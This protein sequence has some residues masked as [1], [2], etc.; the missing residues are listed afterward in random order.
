MVQYARVACLAAL[1]F[2][3]A[4]GQ[5][6]R[7]QDEASKRSRATQALTAE[8]SGSTAEASPTSTY[9]L[10]SLGSVDWAHW[11]AQGFVHKAGANQISDLTQ[12][13]GT[14]D[15]NTQDSRRAA[16]TDGT[17]TASA[18]DDHSYF[19]CNG[20]TGQGFSFTAPASP[21]TRTL[22]VY[23][24]GA[25]YDDTKVKLVAHLEDGSAPDFVETK[26]NTDAVNMYLTTIRYTA[27]S[28]TR[29]KVT[30]T[31]DDDQ[32]GLS[33]DIKAAWLS[34]AAG[35][36]DTTVTFE[37]LSGG[38]SLSSYGGISWGTASAGWKIWD[39]GEAYT[40]NAY[41]D[42]TD[43][44]EVVA[45]F[46]LPA[47]QVL[48][49][50]KV[51]GSGAAA[52]TLKVSS[53]GNPERVWTDIDATIQVKDLGWTTASTTVTVKVTCAS[54]YGAADLG[55]DD[56]V[57]GPVNADTTVTFEDLSDGASLASYGGISWGTESAGWKIWDGGPAYSR[58][59]YV[60]SNATSEVVT[61]FTLPAGQ[62]LKSFKVSG[63]GAAATLKVSSPGNPERVWTD[64]DTT[65][66]VKNLG[67]TSA[68][69]TVTVKVT[70][71]SEYGAADLGFDDLVYG[72][73]LGSASLAGS[74]VDAST[75]T[76]YTLSSLGS[77]DWAHWGAQGFVHKVGADQISDLTMLG[78]SCNT[79]T[80][81]SR[82][83]AWSA[84]SPVAS[85]ADDRSYFWC[86]GV[87]GQGF[88]FTAP[89]SPTQRTLTVYWGGAPY[90]TKVKLVAH[91]EDGSAPDFVQTKT[92]T[93]SVNMYLTTITYAAASDTRLK[94]TLTKDDAISGLSVDIK[95]AWLNAVASPPA[96]A[97]T[98]TF[99]DLSDGAALASY[100]GISWGG[101][102]PAW[103]IWDGGSVL[104]LNAYVDS[105]STSE[106]VATF[107]LPA[108]HVLKSLKI[109]GSGAPATVKFSS[110]GNP[111]RVYTDI[112]T[113]YQLKNLDWTTASSV[114]TVKITCAS[115]WGAADIAFDDISYGPPAPPF[116]P[117]L[118]PD[119]FEW[120]P[121]SL[122]ETR[123]LRDSFRWQDTTALSEVS[124][125]T[126]T[127]GGQQIALPP[128]HYALIYVRNRDELR[129]L[130]ELGIHYE[131]T[132]LFE[133]EWPATEQALRLPFEGD[134][135]DAGGIF[136]YS[137][138]PAQTYNALR[139]LTLAGTETYRAL[140]LR[141]V[142][143]DARAESGTVSWDFL[144]EN[145]RSYAP[146]ATDLTDEGEVVPPREVESATT[147]KKLFNGRWIRRAIEGIVISQKW[148]V[149][150]I[151][152]AI[153]AAVELFAPDLEL[154]IKTSLRDRTRAPLVRAWDD[155][156]GGYG[157]RLA[158]KGVRVFVT[159]GKFAGRLAMYDRDKLDSDGEATLQVARRKLRT[160]FDAE[161]GAAK[162]RFGITLVER[163]CTA[164]KTFNSA[165][166][167]WEI[168]VG[169]KEFYELAQI[170]DARD[171]AA[172]VM[173]FKP[174][175]A[176]VQSGGIGQLL[177]LNGHSFAPCF[178]APRSLPAQFDTYAGAL[179]L[180]GLGGIVGALFQSDIV[181]RA[182]DRSSRNTIVHEYG[183]FVMCTLLDD[184]SHAA[185]DRAWS[186]VI[187][188]VNLDSDASTPVK[189][190]NE[191]FA[192]WFVSQVTSSV[193]YFAPPGSESETLS[194]C[195][196]PPHVVPG[197]R[198]DSDNDC[199]VD[200]VCDPNDPADAVLCKGRCSEY[201]V[202]D[203]EG[204]PVLLCGS[205]PPHVSAGTVCATDNDCA[206]DRVCDP[207]D[208]VLCAGQCTV[209]DG[210]QRFI[211]K[212]VTGDGQGLEANLGGPFCPVEDGIIP[213]GS[214][215]LDQAPRK[216]GCYNEYK[217]W[218]AKKKVVG[219]VATLLHDVIDDG[220]S[221][222]ANT[223]CGQ[224]RRSDA[225]VW[226]ITDPKNTLFNS[227]SVMPPLQ[228]VGD[229]AIDRAGPSDITAVI[230]H[231][232]SL[233]AGATLD[234]ANLLPA[235]HHQLRALGHNDD[236]ICHLFALHGFAPAGCRSIVGDK[237]LVVKFRADPSEGG[238]LAGQSFGERSCALP[239]TSSCM[240]MPAGGL[241]M[242]ATPNQGFTFS[243][244]DGCGSSSTNAQFSLTNVLANA[245][246][247]AHFNRVVPP[248]NVT[249]GVASGSGSI[250]TRDAPS[251]SCGATSCTLPVGGSVT[252]IAVPQAGFD[253][254][255]W[256]G[257]STQSAGVLTLSSISSNQ[258]CRAS[259]TPIPTFTLTVNANPSNG[260]TVNPQT[261]T[262]TRSG[263]VNPR[264]T[265][266]AGFRFDHWSGACSGTSS[267]VW[268]TV[269]SN[270][271]CTAN[272]VRQF[273]VSASASP[274]NGGS[275]TVDNGGSSKTVDNGATVTLR[276]SPSTGFRFDRYVGSAQCTGTNPTLTINS[277]TSNVACTANFVQ[278][279]FTV[280]ATANPGGTATP[281]SPVTVNTG[282]SFTLRATPNAGQLFVGWTGDPSSRCTGTSAALPLSNITSNISCVANFGAIPR[283]T[284]S[285]SPNNANMGSI[286]ASGAPAGSCGAS[287]CTFNSGSSVTLTA[288]PKPGHV[289]VAWSA[290][291]TPSTKLNPVLSLSAVTAN[292]TCSALFVPTYGV[293]YTADDSAIAIASV[294]GRGPCS[295]GVCTVPATGSVTMVATIDEELCYINQWICVAP[296][297]GQVVK[298]ATASISLTQVQTPWVCRAVVRCDRPM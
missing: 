50:F 174:P 221:C 65:I 73:V 115:Q 274:S 29:L 99:Q 184:A 52:A 172:N 70:C 17:P 105:S 293:T 231:I 215:E 97:T 31:K 112:N 181:M 239:A 173:G 237:L 202:V 182:D 193:N 26:T 203:S 131:L 284:V 287:S 79:N 248:V 111:E 285:F 275:V 84:G 232:A 170:I 59:A 68:S 159:G 227:G 41:V 51:S 216:T 247:V 39:G 38:D 228:D 268:I 27:N 282:G 263:R 272:F 292:Q 6:K 127:V 123:S 233:G 89:A 277:V 258:D 80:Q 183:H 178:A 72:P 266:N 83:A 133:S 254:S 200:G 297:T 166:D 49:S 10:S 192:D 188:P 67:W 294:A 117:D 224:H 223:S 201:V 177:S 158:L 217:T 85:A 208:S 124:P 12:L 40:H 190:V 147:Q 20:V 270:V 58:N 53:P 66:Q 164:G 45:T 261:A 198:C 296:L 289:F 220:E 61:T 8:L 130:E 210:G 136:A 98:L 106:V 265:P 101:S 154:H 34:A 175:Q 108:G 69:T 90:D 121:L 100:K 1:W 152:I 209:D 229:E 104:T 214:P 78:G 143:A 283:V 138:I 30:L 163:W 28:N 219:G 267:S 290:C 64:I 13:G 259:F 194:R 207:V 240:V 295:G 3:S 243:H 35:P 199:A 16:W 161:S 2:L 149:D 167:T 55:F 250:T 276:A 137:L 162:V 180:V 9:T 134:P 281:S 57:Y 280:R 110:P 145:L 86:N 278:T 156:N 103:K 60:A 235:L 171:Y 129:E 291:A 109:A 113:S 225:A 116:A 260:G 114:V 74:S 288:T 204:N 42:S 5:D 189:A 153:G 43:T 135:E 87:T 212:G 33:V 62:V 150:G 54:E 264:A 256:S 18:T 132:P 107:R 249:F 22:T 245:E 157:K 102:G 24:G 176:Q 271:T 91:L 187:K 48:K 273:T 94:V 197:T 23:W 238:R 36:G 7:S 253:F 211:S 81:A 82:H 146:P 47:G 122:A 205:L 213:P 88:S 96:G 95:A 4:C 244:W 15:V 63:S 140:I 155:M 165:S 125:R 75:S 206:L 118:D 151:R 141:E 144:L 241:V 252:L 160:C 56:L 226:T 191:G 195:H 21:T 76:T 77:A 269:S 298:S 148:I 11:G 196:E 222:V 236:Q 120:N 218:N 92:N 126:V 186:D 246:C 119:V 19:W 230:R 14:C 142:P 179:N 46:T 139:A 251:G 32:G 25:P 279:V 234:Y 242:T 262:V 168:T 44:S 93:A 37:D 286:A 71:A 255:G 128:M 257:C 185:F 169:D